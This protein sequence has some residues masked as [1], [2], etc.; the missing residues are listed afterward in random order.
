MLI[1]ERI[2]FTVPSFLAHFTKP[3][4][5]VTPKYWNTKMRID[6]YVDSSPSR[7]L[8]ELKSS[9]RNSFEAIWRVVDAFISK[10]LWKEYLTYGPET[11]GHSKVDG[12][13]NRIIF[14]WT[15]Q[16][17][18][19]DTLLLKFRNE[20]RRRVASYL[21]KSILRAHEKFIDAKSADGC[22]DSSCLIGSAR[23]ALLSV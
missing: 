1:E 3:S 23:W 17:H 15:M 5:G 2:N 7:G 4:S 20:W 11:V 16:K 14:M 22:F 9:A 18:V 13:F 21:N 12:I 19:Y 6:S 10:H 8:L